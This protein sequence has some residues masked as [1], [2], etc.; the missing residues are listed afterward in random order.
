[1]TDTVRV[2]WDGEVAT[3][4][5]DR[6]E[7]M[8]ALDGATLVAIENALR[9]IRDDARVLVVTGAGDEAFVAG[10]DIREMAEM[11]TEAAHAYCETG[12]SAMQAVES[13]PAPV[14][15]AVDGHALGGGCELAL[16]ADFRV[17]S[18]RAV[19]G[20]TEIDLGIIPAWGGTQRLVDVVGDETARRL[21]F[22]GERLDAREATEIGLVGEVVAHDA[23]DDRVAEMADELAE[24][25]RFALAAAKEA[26][27]H[28]HESGRQAGLDFERRTWTTLFGTAAQ[29]EGMDAFLDDRDPEFD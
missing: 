20:R 11:D 26:V 14:I 7:R 25:P 18:E 19:L 4:V 28:A 16:A 17:A 13:F 9:R 21:I 15:A 1:M 27:G 2:E 8:N 24:K 3:L 23:L 22:F 12:Q 5:I 29:R 10:A 6:P